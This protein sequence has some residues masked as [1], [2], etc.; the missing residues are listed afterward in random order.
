MKIVLSANDTDAVI[1]REYV[2]DD[3]EGEFVAMPAGSIAYRHP[4]V[5]EL[6]ANV[7]RDA[8]LA[9]ARAW[10]RYVARVAPLTDEGEQLR[11]VE[12]L[13]RELEAQDRLRPD[14]F[15]AIILEQAENGHL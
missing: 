7:S 2:G 15:W 4:V 10:E 14:S 1:G 8:F 3:L 6:F 11:V 12:E 13:R 9:C 5:G